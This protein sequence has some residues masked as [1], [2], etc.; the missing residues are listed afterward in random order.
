MRGIKAE[1]GWG[2]V[3]AE[4]ITIDET[5]DV[6]PF[7]SFQLWDDSDI[8]HVSRIAD[9]VHEHGSLFGVEI[10]HMG[11]AAVNG[12]SRRTALGPSS[13]LNPGFP[14][15][16]QTRRMDLD[17]IRSMRR[18]HRDAAV[19]AQKAGADIV[20]VY[21]GHNESLFTH[22]LYP[23]YNDRTDEYGGSLENRLRLTHEVL[24]EVKEAIGEACAIAMRFAV[25]E[26]A[27]EGGIKADGEG[28]DAVEMLAELPDLWDVNVS[29]WSY[30]SSTARFAE[31]G[32]QE[33]FV[34]FVKGVTNKPVVGVGRFTSP[35]V[36]VSQI[37]RGVLDLIGA[38]RPSI[39]D[40]FLPNKIDEGREDE[41][42]ECIGC[43]ICVSGEMMFSPIRCT[44]N[45]TFLEEWKRDWHPERIAGR[46][47]DQQVLVVG[48][49]PAGLECALQLGKRGYEVLVAEAR[50]EL[51]GRA[52]LE[53]DLPGLSTW[54]RVCD[55]RNNLLQRM[56]NV[57]IYLESELS[58]E[59]VI[60][61]GVPR[62]VIATGARWRRD[63]IGRTHF[64]AIDGL[65]AADVLTPDDVLGGRAP[66]GKIVIYDDD[67]AYLSS[68]IAEHLV[69]R[70]C[71][72]T[73][74]TPHAS[75]APWTE[76]TLEQERIL[77]RMMEV[78]VSVRSSRIISQVRRDLIRVTDTRS[79]CREEIAFDHLVM[80][81]SRLPLD[82]LYHELK[83]VDLSGAGINLIE[84]IG[85]CD[86]PGL[87]ANAVFSG[88]RFARHLDESIK[89]TAIRRKHTVWGP[90]AWPRKSS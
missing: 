27:I 55:Y 49:G 81:T 72:V 33:P 18:S 34:S 35:D 74:L 19:R 78:G 54:R 84:R 9:K 77:R 56:T 52:A 16:V 58:A 48:A 46:K 83:Q 79:G 89:A 88:H 39:A 45:P 5:S 38:A 65:E 36:M 50:T 25:E 69:E 64:E 17:D 8:P 31:E 51:G 11:I 62:V 12:Y 24:L 14:Y 4:W 21:L 57:D 87:I 2:V 75:F 23:R 29:D 44:Q 53:G 32:F 76:L 63:G 6:H 7:P 86:A 59:H 43:N 60:E 90:G 61:F 85:D 41:I 28:R 70:D 67:G 22:F 37:R 47:S 66:G 71:N 42:R 26:L 68:A 73:I 82:R 80:L 13:T 1:G 20:Y 15:P 30:D 40:P 3:C 10:A